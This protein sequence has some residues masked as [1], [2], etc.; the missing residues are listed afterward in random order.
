MKKPAASPSSSIA[1]YGTL[2]DMWRRER[3]QT[4]QPE[5]TPAD[6]PPPKR[7]RL[8]HEQRCAQV[9]DPGDGLGPLPAGWVARLQGPRPYFINHVEKLTQWEDPRKAGK[10]Q[11]DDDAATAAEIAEANDWWMDAS[12]DV[13]DVAA[14]SDVDSIIAQAMLDTVEYL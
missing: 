8:S 6:A 7:P 11:G 10:A 2:V 13:D 5:P 9:A 4:S 1:D 14:P 12:A 3:E